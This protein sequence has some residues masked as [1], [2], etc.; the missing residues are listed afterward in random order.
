MFET[1]GQKHE[2]AVSWQ[3]SIV[4]QAF[5]LGDQVREESLFE[6]PDTFPKGKSNSGAY[7]LGTRPFMHPLIPFLGD[8]VC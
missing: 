6:Q 1:F 7:L 2:L 3:F 8:L 5:A 4:F